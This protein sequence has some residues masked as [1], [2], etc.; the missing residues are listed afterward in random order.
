MLVT[1]MNA[2]TAGKSPLTISVCVSPRVEIVPLLKYWSSDYRL[3]YFFFIENYVQFGI[4][5]ICAR[6]LCMLTL[7]FSAVILML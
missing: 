2:V 4:L 3:R 1:N 7:L 5:F 6:C